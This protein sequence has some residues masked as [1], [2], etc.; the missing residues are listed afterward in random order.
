[1]P[2]YTA[3]SSSVKFFLKMDSVTDPQK[4]ATE[5]QTKLK[6]VNPFGILVSPVTRLYSPSTANSSVHPS[7]LRHAGVSRGG[8]GCEQAGRHADLCLRVRAYK[9][10]N[11]P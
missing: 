7:F 2:V 10:K 9:G 8:R 1:M 6:P 11:K 5:E 4:Q 3:A